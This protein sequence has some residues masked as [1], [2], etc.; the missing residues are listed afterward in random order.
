MTLK[1]RKAGLGTLS[2]LNWCSL[3]PHAARCPS[4][5]KKTFAEIQSTYDEILD[6]LAEEDKESSVAVTSAC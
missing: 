5:K 2:L 4:E 6:S 3:F 1:Y